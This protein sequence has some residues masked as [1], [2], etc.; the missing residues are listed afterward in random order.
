[1][2]ED[3]ER[4]E[5]VR[6]SRLTL[7]EKVKAL[8]SAEANEEKKKEEEVNASA[9]EFDRFDEFNSFEELQKS[10]EKEFPDLFEFEEESNGDVSEEMEVLSLRNLVLLVRAQ[11]YV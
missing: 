8:I 2:Q 3:H 7:L 11:C 10:F 5:R 6:Q 4:V 9:F 1:M